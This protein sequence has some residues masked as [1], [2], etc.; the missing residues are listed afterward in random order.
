M[1]ENDIETCPHDFESLDEDGDG[2]DQQWCPD[3]GLVVSV[4]TK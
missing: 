4:S 3:C 2:P 1:Y